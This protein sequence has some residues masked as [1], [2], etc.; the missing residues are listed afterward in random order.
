MVKN[1]S[2]ILDKNMHNIEIKSESDA[3]Y[4]CKHIANGSHDKIIVGLVEGGEDVG[5]RVCSICEK[6]QFKIYKDFKNGKISEE[7]A[8]QRE[9]EILTLISK[10]YYNEKIKS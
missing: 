8:S 10:D 9:S 2:P 1:M 7:Q 3:M 4:V 6:K 5:I